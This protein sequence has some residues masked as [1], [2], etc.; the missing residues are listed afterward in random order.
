MKIKAHYNFIEGKTAKFLRNSLNIELKSF[1]PVQ[2]PVIQSI[3]ESQINFEKKK[4]FAFYSDGEDDYLMFYYLK[5]YKVNF[6]N[7]LPK[8]HV[9]DCTSRNTY[10]GYFFANKMPV[11]IYSKDGTKK[12]ENQNLSLCKN[13]SK[14]IFKSWWDSSKPWYESVLTYISEEDNP[15][16]KNNGYHTMWKQIS[17][18]YKEKAGWKCENSRC[19][20]DLSKLEDRKYLHTHHINGDTRDNGEDNFK[21]LCLL[22]HGLEHK[23]KLKHGT[24]FYEVENFINQYNINLSSEALKEFNLLK[25]K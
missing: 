14:E 17:E 13:C 2:L 1:K 23:N 4:G 22:C 7:S 18:A 3:K 15:N 8:F 12:Y 11:D 10:S 21:A 20:I 16:F 5:Y 24:G 6:W 9:T 25:S 19:Q